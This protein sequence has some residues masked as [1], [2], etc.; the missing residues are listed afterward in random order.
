MAENWHQQNHGLCPLCSQPIAEIATLKRQMHSFRMVLSQP[1]TS[2]IA[3]ESNNTHIAKLE[4]MWRT[5]DPDA[6]MN[7]CS[8]CAYRL[9]STACEKSNGNIDEPRFAKPQ[10]L[11]PYI[12]SVINENY[13]NQLGE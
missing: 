2:E 9:S 1:D 5:I 7:I 4:E 6:E 11:V 8:K 12:K 3:V 13:K 10:E